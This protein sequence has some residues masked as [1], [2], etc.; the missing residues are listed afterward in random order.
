MASDSVAFWMQ[1][2]L[3]PASAAVVAATTS[4]AARL[5]LFSTEAGG[6]ALGVG[7]AVFA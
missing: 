3:L 7:A 5:S 4:S 1:T 6:G 2:S